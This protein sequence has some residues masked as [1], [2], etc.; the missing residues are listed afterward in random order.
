MGKKTS[1]Y[2]KKHPFALVP[3][4]VLNSVAFQKIPPTAGKL[5]PIFLGKPHL[6]PDAS[7]YYRKEFEFTYSEAERLGVSRST[8]KAALRDL[9]NF[10]FI[11]PVIFGGLRGRH[12]VAS[13]FKLSDRWKKFDTDAMKKIDV[14][15][16]EQE[17]IRRQVYF[18]SSTSAEN[19]LESRG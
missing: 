18:S 3:W 19:R 1:T 8:F 2:A 5:L 11:D 17:R 12:D 6:A 13:R 7:D 15:A 9:I 4:E 16:L 10:G 14:A